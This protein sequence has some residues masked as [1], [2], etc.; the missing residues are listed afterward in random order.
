VRVDADR[1]IVGSG[2]VAT[3]QFRQIPSGADTNKVS[4][5][6]IESP[7]SKL[8]VRADSTVSIARDGGAELS[9]IKQKGLADPKGV[10][11][12][13]AAAPASYLRHVNGVLR[14]EKVTS[15]ADRA[16]ATFFVS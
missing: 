13:S 14:V 15:S 12:A 4:L 6:P 10:S 11:F 3:T 7:A 9:F 16:S 1:I 5:V 2:P 8:V